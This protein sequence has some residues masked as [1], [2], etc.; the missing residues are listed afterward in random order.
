MSKEVTEADFRKPE[1][2]GADPKDYEFD[3][4][5]CVVRKDRWERAIRAL[6][7]PAGLSLRE[8]EIADLVSIAHGSLDCLTKVMV[9]V[10]TIPETSD[11]G[12]NYEPDHPMRLFDD[13]GKRLGVLVHLSKSKDETLTRLMNRCQEVDR[14]IAAA[15]GLTGLQTPIDALVELRK[16]TPGGG[17][18][19]LP[20]QIKQLQYEKR[21]LEKEIA[22]THTCY[23]DNDVNV[24]D[25][26]KD[27]NGQVA[28]GQCKHC[29]KAEI[30]LGQTICT[31]ERK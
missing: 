13:C 14:A 24:P 11:I 30:E 8:F 7:E 2:V 3:G 29:G 5:G 27:S 25:Q 19:S 10:G 16:L 15:I 4:T 22:A 26:I 17:E 23:D 18:K 1:F 6:V 21:E 20:A 9:N 31:G 28:L 12:D